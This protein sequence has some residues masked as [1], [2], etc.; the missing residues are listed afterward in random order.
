LIAGKS[1]PA[2]VVV[3][4]ITT[5]GYLVVLWRWRGELIGADSRH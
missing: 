3:L 4:T 2:M 1:L 5:I